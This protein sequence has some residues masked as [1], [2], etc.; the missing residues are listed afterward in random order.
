MRG[1]MMTQKTSPFLKIAVIFLLSAVV[2]AQSG[3]TFVI[4]K[5]VIAGGGG[6]AAGGTFAL[7]GTIGQS[8]AGTTSSG[9]VFSVDSGFWASASAPNTISGTVTYGNTASGPPPPRFVSNVTLTGTGS[10]NVSTTT[11]PPGASAG[12][13]ALSGFGSGAY[14]VTPSKV[15]GIN[16]AILSLDA[17]A[18]A[19]HVAGP[20]NPQLNATQLIVADVSGN[21]Q[22]TSFDAGM[23]AKF[24]AGPPYAPPGIGSTGTWRFTP[25]NRA[26]ASITS[27]VAGED[28]VALLMGEVTGN[29]A[30]SGA[31]PDDRPITQ[32]QAV[33]TTADFRQTQSA[34]SAG[35]AERSSTRDQ[36]PEIIVD[37]PK[38]A[39][40]DK[41]ITVPVNVQGIADKNIIAYE[42]DLRYDPSV[43]Q[44]LALAADVN[45]TISE[46]LSPIINASE[47]G[48]LRVV[49]YGPNSISE[50]GL[51]INLRFARVGGKG[52][53]SALV[54]ERIIFNE[55]NWIVGANNGQV[56]L[57]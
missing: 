4:E 8:V 57:F 40:D 22:V 2:G 51:L 32:W 16:G 44:P 36:R 6:S 21:S 37:L 31:R 50:N 26:Y 41:H 48:L 19:R 15:G 30:N 35:G 13:Y 56:E 54:I 9:G 33:T 23:I 39:S 45:G 24:A 34:A 10:Q 52:A 25:V 27:S 28:Y 1:K 7:D 46:K 42:F 29:W 11:A 47:P 17:A 14:T 5:N 18:I 43:V 3:G 49:L 53:T 12:Q 20:P 55:G 38:F